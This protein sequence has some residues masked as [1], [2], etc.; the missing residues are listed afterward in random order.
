MNDASD[1]VQQLPDVA[2]SDWQASGGKASRALKSASHHRGTKR[3]IAIAH[4]RFPI[5]NGRISS[6]ETIFSSPSR[7]GE[8]G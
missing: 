1:Q 4:N 8:E 7:G 2:I 5:E 3:A 6:L